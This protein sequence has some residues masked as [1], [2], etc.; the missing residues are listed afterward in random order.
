MYDPSTMYDPSIMLDQQHYVEATNS[1]VVVVGTRQRTRKTRREGGKG[2]RDDE[3][4]ARA[5]LEPPLPTK[6]DVCPSRLTA[7]P[8]PSRGAG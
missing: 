8:A 6:E 4:L 2:I 5:A 3:P 1:I 7:S